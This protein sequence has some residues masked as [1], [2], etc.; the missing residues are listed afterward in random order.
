MSELSIL[1]PESLT[2]L[3]TKQTAGKSGTTVAIKRMSIAEFAAKRGADST[4]CRRDGS[5]LQYLKG[6]DSL[7]TMLVEAFR[8]KGLVFSSTGLA[9]TNRG[10]SRAVSSALRH[11]PR[12]P[13]PTRTTSLP[14]R[15]DGSLTWK[16]GSKHSLRREHQNA[17]Q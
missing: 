7:P 9:Q 13:S 8:Q 11:L 1:N 14:I 12:G 10:I 17:L 16:R 6:Y 5:Y 3:L 15:R 4:T 2:G